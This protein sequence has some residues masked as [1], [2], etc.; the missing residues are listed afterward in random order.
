[1]TLP[2]CFLADLSD[3]AVLTPTM[4]RDAC[5]SV[6]SNRRQYLAER[7]TDAM[8]A[9]L[10]GVAEDWMDPANPYRR[11]ALE[12]GPVEL[13]FSTATLTA[14][15]DAF[16]RTLTPEALRALIR[17]DLG[18]PQRLDALSAAESE[19]FATRVA[20]ARGPELLVH[21]TGGRLPNPALTS[22]VLGLLLRSAQFMKCARGTSLLPR[23]FAHSL[24]EV[25][26]KLGACLE[27][28]EWPGGTEP[29]EAAL[30]AQAD[31]VT[32]TGDDD[33]LAAIRRRIPDGV[34][35]TPYGHRVSFAYV[36]QEALSHG[37]LSRVVAACAR[38]VVAWN[39]LG[40]LSPHAI[41]VET[42]SRHA[43]SAFAEG[44]ADELARLEGTEPRGPVAVEMAAAIASRRAFY[45]VRAAHSPETRLWASAGNTNW[46]VVY[47]DDP[48]F[49]LSC[50][51]RF[52]YVKAV[53]D[54][55]QALSGADSVRGRVSTIGLA[56]SG[57]KEQALALQFAHWG[58]SRICPV[59][60]MQQ[61]PL[62]WRH[63]GRPSLADLVTWTDWDLPGRG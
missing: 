1:M 23:L 59:G 24:R 33:T 27:I 51:H 15:L 2:A 30:F 44:L 6:K 29:L 62:A 60:Q 42:G 52:I 40:C 21:I 3:A 11:L 63:D 45:E 19:I 22:L 4:V 25:E 5:L 9:T 14:G 20:L 48:R 43:P 8:I 57:L 7:N 54:V 35:F 53:T 18:H 37:H 38:D 50:L 34:R 16:F 49:Q 10:A 32:A 55:G 36:A 12:R 58:A 26:P 56:A 13:G 46:T 28:A 17:Q 39:Q 47:E 41:Y 61:P 31:G